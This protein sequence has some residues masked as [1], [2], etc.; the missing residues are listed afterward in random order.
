MCRQPNNCSRRLVSRDTEIAAGPDFGRGSGTSCT[1]RLYDYDYDQAVCIQWV[2][3]YYQ[4]KF[5]ISQQHKPAKPGSPVAPELFWAGCSAVEFKGHPGRSCT[6]ILVE[7]EGAGGPAVPAVFVNVLTTFFMRFPFPMV[8]TG[9]FGPEI[10]FLRL[11]LSILQHK[12]KQK[13]ANLSVLNA[14]NFPVISTVNVGR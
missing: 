11:F 10:H 6:S 14:N 9:N 13:Q 12:N 4:R 7:L 1:S 3:P 5:Q 8:Y 2:E